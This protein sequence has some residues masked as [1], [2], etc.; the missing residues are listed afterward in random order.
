MGVGSKVFWIGEY[1]VWVWGVQCLVVRSTVSGGEKYIVWRW[2]V[3]CLVLGSTMFGGG[4]YIVWRWGVQSLPNV[5]IPRKPVSATPNRGRADCEV[6][7][8]PMG[9]F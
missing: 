1:S 2:G 7:P 6:K 5:R 3:Q 8:R 9:G 4:Q